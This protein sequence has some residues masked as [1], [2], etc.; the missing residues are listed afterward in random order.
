MKRSSVTLI[1]ITGA[2]AL[3]LVLG[4]TLAQ[5][6]RRAAAVPTR[7][8]V[9]DVG[10]LFNGY[11]RRDDLNA[12]LEKKRGKANA[13]DK[14]RQQSI[15]T[16]EKALEQLKPGTKAYQAQMDRLARLKVERSAWRA[17]EEKAFLAEHRRM[18]EELYR[19]I[20]AAVALTAKEK[21][22]DLVV[23][24]EVVEIASQTTTELYKKI[25]QRKCLFYSPKIDLTQI[26]LE[27][28][29]R[30]YRARKK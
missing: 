27:R 12:E 3:A 18:M 14:Q 2:V 9:C 17:Y 6:P 20:L 11:A 4:Q 13:E 23:Y 15:E 25:A 26:V 22:Y 5:A 24:S 10:A 19:E 16:F 30:R 1:S 8:A 7:V 21:G 28:M 29:N